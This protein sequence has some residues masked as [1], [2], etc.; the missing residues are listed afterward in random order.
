MER[1]GERMSTIDLFRGA[2]V[3]LVGRQGQAWI[4]AARLVKSEYAALPLE[5]Y[6]ID[7]D[8]ATAYGLSVSGASLVRPDGFVAWRSRSAESDMAGE[9][10]R[11]FA[12][13]LCRW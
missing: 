13:I 12:T 10:R 7:D 2:F 3:L 5:T 8:V 1:N 4:D 9:L 11:T 6:S